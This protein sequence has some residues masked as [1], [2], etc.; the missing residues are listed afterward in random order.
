M[1]TIVILLFCIINV[2][3]VKINIEGHN[4]YLSSTQILPLDPSE[5][6]SN[7]APLLRG[8]DTNSFHQRDILD[9]YGMVLREDYIDLSK[10]MNIVFY[11][12]SPLETISVQ[13]FTNEEPIL[14]RRIL[15]WDDDDHGS[16]YWYGESSEYD[17]F[18]IEM[19]NFSCV[20]G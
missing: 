6:S 15:Y 14:F 12:R 18:N 3:S 9:S 1:N 20:L 2:I 13:F 17:T 8:S 5:V 16:V 10:W 7:R 11:Q 19:N 4:E